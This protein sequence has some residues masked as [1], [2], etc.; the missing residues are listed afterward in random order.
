MGGESDLLFFSR[1]IGIDP[2]TG[3]EVPVNG[4]GKITGTLGGFDVGLMDISTREEGPNPEANYGVARVKRSLFG[5]S[6]VGAMYVDKRSGSPTDSY[7]QTGGL[8]A[9][10]VVH[11]DVVLTG[12]G[13]LTRSPELSSGQN[14][15][16]ASVSYRTDFVDFVAERRRIGQ[17]FNPEVG[18][19]ERNNCLCDFADLTLK[20]RPKLKGIREL[21]F[22]RRWRALCN[23]MPYGS[24]PYGRV[25][26]W[27][28]RCRHANQKVNSGEGW[29]Q[30][31]PSS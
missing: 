22:E 4:G 16:G 28:G 24:Q 7:N 11:K 30:G 27:H 18:F 19:I 31:C 20:P 14:N 21:E 8:D 10:F 23:M 29:L 26:R 2:V 15:A 1:Q 3:Q 9:R 17:N 6:Y 12:F 25:M 5:E 13:V